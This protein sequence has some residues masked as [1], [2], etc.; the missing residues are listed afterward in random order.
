MKQ[1]WIYSKWM[2]GAFILAPALLISAII[3]LFQNSFEAV[4]TLPVWLWGVLVI[5]VD[6]A[7]VYSTIFRTYADPKE[8]QARRTLYTLT[9]LIC[10]AVGALLYSIDGLV[11][12]RAITYFAVFHFIRQQYG[13]MMIYSRNEK[14]TK[15]SRKLDELAIYMATLYPL[16][17]WHTHLPRH[18]DWF[19]EGDFMAVNLPWLNTIAFVLYMMVL[20]VYSAKEIWKIIKVRSLNIPK[21]LLLFGTVISWWVGVVA[22]NND[23][24]FSTA[25]IIAHGVPYIAL[26]WI[27]GR[28]QGQVEPTRKLFGNITMQNFFTVRLLPIFIGILLVLAYL[29]EG[30]WDGFIWTEHKGM[31]APFHI[32][33]ATYDKATLAWL[34][35]LLALPQLTHY[36][37]DAFI[38]RMRSERTD[39]KQVLFYKAENNL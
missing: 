35:P 3:L 22:F 13:F 24:T 37:L 11:F 17:Y 32:L 5:C 16:I 33:P 10:W 9:P 20:L 29:E 15:S 34:V 38:W 1:P 4:E 28:N 19:I 6:V 7:H 2:D 21:N 12:W 26:I 14:R 8:F 25:N 27:Y 30:L 23:I 36:A 31:F 18:F 39:W